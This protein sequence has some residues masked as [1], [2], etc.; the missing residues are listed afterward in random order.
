MKVPILMLA[1]ALLA[2]TVATG[3]VFPYQYNVQRLDN[4]LKV[5]L[6]PLQARAWRRTTRGAY[7]EP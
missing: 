2:A 3:G 7:R 4:G 1:T 6:I 5:I